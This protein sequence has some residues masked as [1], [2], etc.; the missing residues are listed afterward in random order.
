MKKNYDIVG[1]IFSAL[2]GA[3]CIITPILILNTPN[4]GKKFESPW[5]QT[6]LLILIAGIFYQS[7]WRSFKT[8][9]SKLTLGLGLSG[10]LILFSTYLNELLAGHEHH[11]EHAHHH[12][13]TFSIVLAI[14]G[15]VLMI[16][17]HLLNIRHCKCS[18]IKPL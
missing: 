13:E 12:E 14:L 3:H 4:I 2:C 18:E 1:I 17:S 15:S 16:S 5:V 8:H 9:G 11:I 7:V 6:I 10:F